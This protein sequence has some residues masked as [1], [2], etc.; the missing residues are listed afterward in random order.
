MSECKNS[1]LLVKE[2][3]KAIRYCILFFFDGMT[4]HAIKANGER[5]RIK[6]KDFIIYQDLYIKLV[7]LHL[8]YVELIDTAILFALFYF[9]FS[10]ES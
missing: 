7:E 10:F 9:Y 3:C 6:Y 2:L 5:V 4:S 1:L 8:N